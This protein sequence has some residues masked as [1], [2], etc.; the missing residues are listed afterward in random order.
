M[1]DVAIVSEYIGARRLGYLRLLEIVENACKHVK[2]NTTGMVYRYYSRSEKQG[3]GDQIKDIKK[4]VEKIDPPVNEEKLKSLHDIVGATIVVY[5]NTDIEPIYK[6]IV[7]Y[8]KENGVKQHRQ[9]SVKKNGY[10]ATHGIFL[11][12]RG[13]TVGLLCELQIKT[14]LH[15]AWSAKMH[16]LTYKPTGSIDQRLEVLMGAI[17]SQIES[18]EDQSI[19]VRNM[20]ETRQKI[21]AAAFKSYCV[22][23]FESL[24]LALAQQLDGYGDDIKSIEKRIDAARSDAQAGTLKSEEVENIIH[25]I[26]EVCAEPPKLNFGWYLIAKLSSG[27]MLGHNA[28]DVAHHVDIFLRTADPSLLDVIGQIPM[29]FYVSGD[30]ARAAEYTHKIQTGVLAGRLSD[31]DAMVL[32][33]NR[34]CYLLEHEHLKPSRSQIRRQQL[35]TDIEAFLPRLRTLNAPEIKSALQDT[36]GLLDIV[37]GKTPEEVRR[38]IDL[39]ITA[40]DLA[41]TDYDRD[42]AEKCREWRIQA[43]WRKYY[44]LLDRKS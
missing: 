18:I 19:V 27:G 42:I 2:N 23:L 32:E 21:E 31:K 11:G 44:D 3:G 28:D 16:D 26:S 13:N 9:P 5:Y 43:G 7:Q 41:T 14:V 6:M 25:R 29:A 40:P 8:L 17:A 24:G 38:G 39:C 35:K 12:N 34:F 20:I 15:D 37:Y 33:F 4:I 1:S 10:Y 22:H 30:L 36:Y